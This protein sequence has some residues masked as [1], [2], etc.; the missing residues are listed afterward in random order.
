MDNVFLKTNRLL[1]RKISQDDFE[2]LTKILKNTNVMWAWEYKFTDADVQDWIDK[3]LDC[4]EKYNLGFFIVE[5]KTN[6]EIL[7]QVALKPDI[8]NG[9]KCFEIGYIFKKQNWKKGYAKESAKALV[10]YAFDEL[11]LDKVIFEIRPEN[12]A[13][14]NVAKSLGAKLTGEFVKI[15]KGKKMPHLIYTIIQYKDLINRL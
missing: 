8:I 4:Y 11:N 6:K 7:G 12:E 1:I 13:S 10:Q 2:E 5:D 3:T 14:I 9:E 15:V